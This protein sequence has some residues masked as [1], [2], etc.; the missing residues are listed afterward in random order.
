MAHEYE[1]DTDNPIDVHKAGLG[2]LEIKKTRAMV[3]E[4][5]DVDHNNSGIL[6]ES[7][8]QDGTHKKLTLKALSADPTA[9][10]GAGI[11]YSKTV[12]GETDLYYRTTENTVRITNGGEIS[13]DQNA[14][15]IGS[16]TAKNN[17]RTVEDII[18]DEYENSGMAFTE[19][20]ISVAVAIEG[21]YL[22]CTNRISKI[23]IVSGGTRTNVFNKNILNNHFPDVSN[24]NSCDI[25]V[26]YLLE[27]NS[28]IASSTY[29][30]ND[31][32]SIV[33]SKI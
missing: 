21:L 6:D 15:F 9:V 14:Y 3:K 19:G 24:E 23:D 7:A 16:F 10:S 31:V 25:F 33:V 1:F 17:S 28:I 11:L 32:L 8:S 4:R 20:G 29:D 13:G 22:I 18:F 12:E 5:F 26:F 2:A 27:G 30:R